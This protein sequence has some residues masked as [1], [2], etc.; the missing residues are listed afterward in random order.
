MASG[1]E[2]GSGVVLAPSLDLLNPG[3]PNFLG[4]DSAAGAD[5]VV[6]AA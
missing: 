4:F 1:S 3:L 6:E 5:S 2:A